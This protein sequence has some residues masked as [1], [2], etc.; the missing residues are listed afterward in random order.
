MQGRVG[1][2]KIEESEPSM[3]DVKHDFDTEWPPHKREWETFL[4]EIADYPKWRSHFGKLSESDAQRVWSIIE[5]QFFPA[6]TCFVR[7]WPDWCSSGIW[8]VPFPGSRFAGWMLDPAMHLGISVELQDQFKRWQ[9][10]FDSHA[11]WAA[12]EEFDWFAFNA[13][14]QRL[15]RALKREVGESVYVECDELQEVLMD[16]ITRNWRPVLGLPETPS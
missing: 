10:S 6:Y 9:A 14:E 11:P 3:A 13:E 15:T 2:V 5:Q 16:G 12:P 8:Q 7:V 4:S 1:I